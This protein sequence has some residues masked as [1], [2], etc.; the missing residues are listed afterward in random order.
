LGDGAVAGSGRRRRR[1]RRRRMRAAGAINGRSFT[2]CLSVHSYTGSI[3]K[4]TGS[5]VLFGLAVRSIY[6]QMTPVNT[7]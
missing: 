2:V 6:R 3:T 7:Y 1:R 4:T 5:F